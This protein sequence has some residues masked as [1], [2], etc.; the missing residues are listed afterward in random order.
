MGIYTKDK[1]RLKI[2]LLQ[3]VEKPFAKCLI[4]K[5]LVI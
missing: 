3:T 2:V 4:C 1:Y 5:L